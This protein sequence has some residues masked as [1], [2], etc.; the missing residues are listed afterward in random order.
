MRRPRMT[1]VLWGWRLEGALLIASYVALR[2][3]GL[4]GP[5]GPVLLVGLIAIALW[6]LPQLRR[7]L[8][9]RLRDSRDRRVVTSALWRCQIFGR[10]GRMPRVVRLTELPVGKS[11]LL[12]LP[13]GLHSAALEPRIPEI[14]AATGAREARLRPHRIAAFAELVLVTRDVLECRIIGSPILHSERTSLWEPIPLGLG[15]DGGPMALSLPEHNLLIGGEP[16][17]GKSVVLSSIVA[18]GALDPSA[19]LTLL[20]GKQ[21]ELA[22]WRTVAE[23]FVGPD[24]ADATET[25]EFLQSEMD[26]RY[27]RLLETRRRKV[28]RR[29]EDGLRLVVVDELALYL[30]GGGSKVLRERFAE[31]LRD[32]VSRGRAAGVIVVAATQK[33]SHEVVPTFVRDLFS[34]RMAMRCTSPDA[35]DTILGQGWTTRGYSASTIDPDHRG[36]GYLLAEGGVPKRFRAPFLSDEDVAVL[37]HRAEVLRSGR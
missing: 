17:S 8:I 36:V 20:D 26:L 14:A 23:R 37:A 33:P 16:G 18:V 7:S 32:L 3:A 25:L 24:L 6:Q 13:A 31:A 10:D 22:I 30:R 11:Y 9:A 21:V 12:R 27:R 28:E 29:D 2:F 5:G 4:L 15:E 34:Y 1:S 19:T 35:S